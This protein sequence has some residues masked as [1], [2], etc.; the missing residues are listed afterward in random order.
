MIK[1]LGLVFLCFFGILYLGEKHEGLKKPLYFSPPRALKHFHFG[2]SDFMADMLWLR[3][4][5]NADF[6]S[7]AKG[8]PVYKGGK[9]HCSKGWA[10]QMADVI[11]ELA[12]RFK[13]P[14]T[15]S[16]VMISV[17]A[18]D[19]E[20]AKALLKKG[21][22]AFPGDKDM[23][24]SAAYFY[25]AEDLHMKAALHAYQ[26]AFYGGP[27]WLY[28]YAQKSFQGDQTGLKKALLK[29]LLKWGGLT[30]QQ[31]QELKTKEKQ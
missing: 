3:Y 22:R 28:R 1:A 11:T 26:A 15:F 19:R 24:F 5:Q 2:F 17:F 6:C 8:I 21:L 20:G 9:K 13:T 14:Y 29:N 10:Y 7:L 23:H 16:T 30:E 18:G 4:L 31:R 12:P 27:K 25:S